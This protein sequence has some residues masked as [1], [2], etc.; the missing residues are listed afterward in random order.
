[1]S[2]ALDLARRHYA[3]RQ[4]MARSA[5]AEGRRLWQKVD[6]ANLSG[7]WAP[8]LARLLVVVTSAQLA[9][10]RAADRYVSETL[11]AQGLDPEPAGE[12]VAESLAG[13]ASDGRDLASLLLNPVIATKRAIST[14]LRQFDRIWLDRALATGQATLE[15]TMRTQVA[16]AG[17]VADGIAVAVRPR[18]GYVRMLVGDSCPRCVILAGR[19]YRYSAGFERH[20]N[21]DCVHIPAA[22]D[23]ADDFTTDPRKAFEEGRVRGLSQADTHAIQEGADLSQVV[24]AHRGMYTAG[25]QKRTREG[26]TRRGIAGARLITGDPTAFVAPRGDAGTRVVST[27]TRQTKAGPRTVRIRGAQTARLMPEQIYRDASS[28]DEAVQMLRLHGYIL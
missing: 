26:I 28:R 22:E 9:A 11:A 19:F 25:G 6:P 5:A 20:P 24:N 16:D 1:M 18:T 23:T 12:V 14:Q 8:M 4:R 7:S 27:H 17:R 2:S 10:A 21:C 13:I 3:T 15:M